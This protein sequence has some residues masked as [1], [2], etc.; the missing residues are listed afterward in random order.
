MPLGGVLGTPDCGPQEVLDTSEVNVVLIC[1][2]PRAPK[3]LPQGNMGTSGEEEK[4][5]VKFHHHCLRQGTVPQT[6]LGGV[7]KENP[8][9]LAFSGKK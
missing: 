5:T 9:L 3:P 4:G 1:G 7:L 8:G 2:D 6:P